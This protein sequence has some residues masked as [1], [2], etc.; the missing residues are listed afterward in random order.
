MQLPAGGLDVWYVDESIDPD[1]I[2][3]SAIAVPFLR[4]VDGTWTITWEDQLKNLRDWRRGL[5]AAHG[6][7]TTK[8]LKASK[9]VGGRGR[10]DRGVNQL[11]PVAAVTAYRWG[12]ANLTFLQP[13]SIIS[14]V[15]KPHAN[16]YGHTRLTAVLYALLQRMR[17]ATNK[18]GRVGMVF[19]DE[20]HGE[21]R[22]LYRKAR[23]NLPTGSALGGWSSGSTKNLPLANFVKDANFKQS[24]DCHFTQVADLLSFAVRSKIRGELG[25]LGQSQQELDVRS[26]YDVVPLTVLNTRASTT[27][28]QGIV[29]LG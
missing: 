18:L 29:R 12:L 16:L 11:K 8:E 26:L 10:Y 14:V 4:Q 2:A 17:T 23:T 24:H 7:P 15:A 6:I 28:R 5:S 22:T 3:M 9:L 27:D 1:V 25:L 19:F 21:Y 20:G 13:A